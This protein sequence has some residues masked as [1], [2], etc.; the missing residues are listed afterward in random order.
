MTDWTRYATQY[1]LI[2]EHNPA[3][4][5]ILRRFEREVAGWDLPS[6]GLFADLGAGTGNFS[7][8]AAKALPH[9]HV[10]HVD[11]D[12]GMN[13]V[14]ER[15]RAELDLDNLEIRP[16]SIEELDLAPGQLAAVSCVHALYTLDEPWSALEDIGRWLAPGGRAFL[17][18]LGRVLDIRDWFT[19][20]FGGMRR[21]IGVTGAARVVWQGRE[22]LRQNR[23]I[24]AAQL[25][26]RYWTHDTES[27][28]HAVEAAGMRV[29]HVSTCFRGYSDLVVAERPP[30]AMP[31]RE[32][33]HYPS[34]SKIST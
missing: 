26:G 1:D 21:R 17:C 25:D 14:A 7:L 19:Y 18:D 10:L 2:L 30:L 28:L 6:G 23:A 20:F 4:Q 29:L 12:P 24:R 9:T 27:F 15:K 33:D 3:Y 31:R 13:A 22:V 34:P 11:R 32:V 16:S 5:D 8:A